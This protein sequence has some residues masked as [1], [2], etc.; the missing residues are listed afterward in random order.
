MYWDKDLDF[1][2]TGYVLPVFGETHFGKQF[3]FGKM[4]T[5]RKNIV[6]KFA[7]ICFENFEIFL[8]DQIP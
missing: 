1:S 7:E 3:I 8:A 4:G 2:V 5:L 6:D